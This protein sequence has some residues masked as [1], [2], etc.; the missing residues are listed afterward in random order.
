MKQKEAERFIG[1]KIRLILTNQ[2]HFTGIVLD[3]NEETLSLKDKFGKN[4]SIKLSE[5]IIFEET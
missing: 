1:K 5:I 2:Y 3:C 4:V